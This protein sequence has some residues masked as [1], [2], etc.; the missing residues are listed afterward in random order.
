MGFHSILSVL[1]GRSCTS[2]TIAHMEVN[3]EMWSTVSPS[4]VLICEIQKSFSKALLTVHFLHFEISKMRGATSLGLLPS[5]QEDS[6]KRAL[7]PL[8]MVTFVAAAKRSRSL[9]LQGFPRPTHGLGSSLHSNHS[10]LKRRAEANFERLRMPSPPRFLGLHNFSQLT[11]H[12][13]GYSPS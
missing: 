10:H 3:W 2:L 6:Q 11:L 1:F 12:L 9:E 5:S 4:W 13:F 8:P 7:S